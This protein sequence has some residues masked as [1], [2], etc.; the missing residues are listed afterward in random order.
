MSNK[1]LNFILTEKGKNVAFY[2]MQEE[3]KFAS[4]IIIQHFNT[5]IENKKFADLLMAKF[6]ISDF[7]EG[8]NRGEWIIFDFG[9]TVI[10]SFTQDKRE[11]YNLDKMW[12]SAKVVISPKKSKK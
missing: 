8:Y 3:M 12:Q 10:H 2:Q 4:S 5:V 11:K 7:P 9:D 6:N 1:Y